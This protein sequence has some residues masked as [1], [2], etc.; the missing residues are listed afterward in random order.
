MSGGRR[1]GRDLAA[2]LCVCTTVLVMMTVVA[3]AAGPFGRDTT[4]QTQVIMVRYR[5]SSW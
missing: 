1:T 5:E 3:V 4:L 2:D